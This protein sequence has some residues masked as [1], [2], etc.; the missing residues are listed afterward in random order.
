MWSAEWH[1]WQPQVPSL[2]PS[3]TPCHSCSVQSYPSCCW[4]CSLNHLPYQLCE[5]P[6]PGASVT[7][8]SRSPLPSALRTR[9]SERESRL[10]QNFDFQCFNPT[11]GQCCQHL[12]I[13]RN[14]KSTDHLKNQLSYPLPCRL[15]THSPSLVVLHCFGHLNKL[16][17]NHGWAKC[18][19]PTLWEHPSTGSPSWVLCSVGAAISPASA[20]Q[21]LPPGHYPIPVIG[22]ATN[23]WREKL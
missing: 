13:L 6:H 19:N 16:L 17:R 3:G 9:S 23:K 8:A 5:L 10:F 2:P 7:R 11:T 20:P 18:S 1:R 15:Q 4:H 12:G 22:K 14:R 21:A